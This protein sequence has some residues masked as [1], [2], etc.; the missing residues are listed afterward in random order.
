[1]WGRGTKIWQQSDS[2]QRT[3]PEPLKEC[4]PGVLMH[5]PSSLKLLSLFSCSGFIG[6]EGSQEMK[7]R[8][9]DLFKQ[10]D[11]EG[12]VEAYTKAIQFCPEGEANHLSLCYQNRAAANERLGNLERVIEDC[13]TALSLNLFYQKA[14]VRRGR[15]YVRLGELENALD[16]FTY[17]FVLDANAVDHFAADTDKVVTELC[18]TFI[19]D[20]EKTRRGIPIRD[21]QVLLWQSCYVNDSVLSDLKK[22]FDVKSCYGK[23]LQAIKD[24]R[25]EEVIGLLE[26][27]IDSGLNDASESLRNYILLTRFA[28]MKEDLDTMRKYLDRFAKLW[29]ALDEEVKNDPVTKHYRAM[30]YLL[31]AALKLLVNPPLLNQDIQKAVEA[32]RD[33]V[34]V[35]LSAAMLLSESGQFDLALEYLEQLSKINPKHHLVNHM[36]IN[37]DL[38]MKA[39]AGDVAGTFNA[40][41]RADEL[42]KA[43]PDADPV[44][45]LITGRL[46]FAAQNVELAKAAFKKAAEGL[47]EYSAPIFYLAMVEV[48]EAEDPE[49]V[50][51]LEEKMK[52]CLEKEK[53]NPDALN[54]LA[55]IACQ[56]NDYAEAKRL[57]EQSIKVCPL[58][59]NKA[60]M[61]RTVIDYL[62]ARAMCKAQERLKVHD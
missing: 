36:K 53:A 13:S 14:A 48:E 38:A 34:D 3:G 51:A 15:A 56:R 23:V 29:A 60:A 35:Y 37:F 2:Q 11:Y 31:S 46:Y 42:L 44:L 7:K 54:I 25:Y 47:P 17:A 49:R 50:Q 26:N 21:E 5:F 43:N 19:N 12:A 16:D 28:L 58:R 10:K 9:N 45:H 55:R 18:D 61:Q 6:M 57:F 33:N 27:D 39:S 8:G 32:D 59:S 52:L 22:D 4:L 40:V 30:Y 24:H 20:L 1:M 41:L 62:Q